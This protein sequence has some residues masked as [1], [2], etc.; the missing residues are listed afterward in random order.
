MSRRRTVVAALL[1][2]ALAFITLD[3][4]E[5]GGPV[6]A[7]QRGADTVFAPIQDGFATLVSPIAG[8]F[9]SILEIGTL[10]EENAAL[11][12]ENEALR[13]NRVSLAD[14]ERQNQELRAL[15]NMADRQEVTVVGARVIARP[16]GDFDRSVLIDSGA[17]QGVAV[18]MAVINDRGVV[19]LVTEVSATRARVE[20]ASSN[21]GNLVVR[22][23]ET[24]ALG[25][26]TG[27]G[28]GP[29]RLELV[30]SDSIVPLD[31]EIVT[32]AFVGSLVP[33]GLPVGRLIDPS[34]GTTEGERF[35][36]VRPFV[37]FGSL[38]TVGV[39]I[40]GQSSDDEIDE[41]E[42]IEADILPAP[43]ITR[44]PEP[45]DPDATAEPLLIP[46]I[47]FPIPQ[48][49]L[50]DASPSPSPTAEGG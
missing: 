44:T 20:L 50:P 11:R 32:Q 37:D 38:S 26:L 7:L 41:D 40:S 9:G 42:R 5:T 23:A 8:F 46:G 28:A 29:L 21:D 16:P 45:P 39:V 30:D 34:D 12:E 22:V 47:D 43:R 1:L 25:L 10:R 2:V 36:E 31:A 3:F 49:V 48:N 19:G 4:R 27:Q 14:L 35:L 33:G 13:D 17:A 24:S 18:G 6:G 15:L